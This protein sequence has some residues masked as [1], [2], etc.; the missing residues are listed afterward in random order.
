MSQDHRHWYRRLDGGLFQSG[1]GHFTPQERYNSFFD[2][3]NF[4]CSLGYPKKR[5][6]IKRETSTAPYRP[7]LKTV[8]E[9]NGRCHIH[10]GDRDLADTTNIF[11]MGVSFKVPTGFVLAPGNEV[12]ILMRPLDS[13]TMTDQVGLYEFRLYYLNDSGTPKVKLDIQTYKATVGAEVKSCT[14]TVTFAA[15][16]HRLDILYS[17]NGTP[18]GEAIVY[19]DAG[20]G[21]GN[22]GTTTFSGN[23]LWPAPSI[24]DG[25][26]KL[27][28]AGQV[29]VGSCPGDD[30]EKYGFT[31]EKPA[32]NWKFAE[33]RYDNAY[34]GTLSDDSGA[35][36]VDES[37]TQLDGADLDLVI[38]MDEG[39]GLVMDPET[40]LTFDD[41]VGCLTN[42]R[43]AWHDS[44][45]LLHGGYYE[46]H[47]GYVE[48]R[49]A[50]GTAP[51]E[52]IAGKDAAIIEP[53]WTMFFR[54]KIHE[55][56][57][58][59]GVTD[60]AFNV[61]ASHGFTDP[62]ATDESPTGWYFGFL[63]SGANWALGI[64]FKEGNAN[65]VS[66]F[67]AITSPY[68]GEFS[69]TFVRRNDGNLYY[70]DS[71]GGTGNI[72]FASTITMQLLGTEPLVFGAHFSSAVDEGRRKSN[73]K[74][75]NVVLREFRA[76]PYAI[77]AT[78]AADTTWETENADPSRDYLALIR[79][80][81]G[82]GDTCTDF[83]GNRL[84]CRI[85][86]SQ[87]NLPVESVTKLQDW[88]LAAGEYYVAFAEKPQSVRDEG[89][90][91]VEGTK[92]ALAAGQWAWDAVNDRIYVKDDPTNADMEALT[93]RGIVRYGDSL[94]MTWSYDFPDIATR[95]VDAVT[96]HHH[97]Q[98]GDKIVALGDGTAWEVTGNDLVPLDSDYG[99][100]EVPA[101]GTL[102]YMQYG[103][104]IYVTD[105]ANRPQVLEVNRFRPAGLEAPPDH[106]LP[107]VRGASGSNLDGY[108]TYAIAYENDEAGA[109]SDIAVTDPIELDN[110]GA[111]IGWH[112]DALTCR[113]FNQVDLNTTGS[114][115][116]IPA[117]HET[118]ILTWAP[119]D[120]WT[121]EGWIK[122]PTTATA[123]NINL[124]I[125]HK[126][127]AFTT[128]MFCAR[129]EADTMVMKFFAKN[130]ASTT[131]PQE[132][133]E[134]ATID[135][136]RE[137]G[138]DGEVKPTAQWFHVA[139]VWS[140]NSDAAD[141]NEYWIYLN[142]LLAADGKVQLSVV[143]AAG[144]VRI[145]DAPDPAHPTI[146]AANRCDYDEWRFWNEVRTAEQILRFATVPVAYAQNANLIMNFSPSDN[147]LDYL[148]V[149]ARE[150]AADGDRVLT[151]DTIRYD[152][153]NPIPRSRDFIT[154]IRIYRSQVAGLSSAPDGVER[155]AAK[156]IAEGGPWYYLGRVPVD[157]SHY[158]DT[159]LAEMASISDKRE[160]FQV[161]PP[162][163]ATSYIARY[164]AMAVYAKTAKYPERVWFSRPYY[165]EEL[166]SASTWFDVEDGSGEPITALHPHRGGLLVF[167][168]SSI[169]GIVGTEPS[170]LDV[171]LVAKG[172][173]TEA[174]RS[175]VEA[176]GAV[177]FWSRHGPAILTEGG[178]IPLGKG[179]VDVEIAK[180]TDYTAVIGVSDPTRHRVG[181]LVPNINDHPQIL[182]FDHNFKLWTRDTPYQE[183]ADIVGIDRVDSTE[184]DEIWLTDDKGYI[185]R[186][187]QGTHDGHM[188]HTVTLYGTIA[189]GTT[190]TGTF[191]NTG[192]GLTGLPVLI[193]ND[194]TGAYTWTYITTNTAN[195]A[196]IND[197][198]ASA[199]HWLLGPID[200]FLER[201]W[202]DWS[203]PNRTKHFQKFYL[204]P[205]S[206]D[207]TWTVDVAVVRELGELTPDPT[208]HF[209]EEVGYAHAGAAADP[210]GRFQFVI[211]E[212]GE[213][214][215]WIAKNPLPDS[216]NG[217]LE[218]GWEGKILPGTAPSTGHGTTSLYT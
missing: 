210:D 178:A 113:H 202:S 147:I 182:W 33:F 69:M 186:Y 91:L 21:G 212:M 3:S 74:Q 214:V 62:T 194:A 123:S 122:V 116:D 156:A 93:G 160:K 55:F 4:D 107:G 23:Y 52:R 164:G 185:Y 106:A 211:F 38:P 65:A 13:G 10:F 141:G 89:T 53:E 40:G 42:S 58:E 166:P 6:G 184:Q 9:K 172:V 215:K 90:N 87:T 200:F 119:G 86:G 142:G 162:P 80:Q 145:Y 199:S 198:V 88:T 148:D 47:P 96:T 175:V 57:G 149:V 183:Y 85:L 108:V 7:C 1:E 67:K 176:Q 24:A 197:S 205:S 216:P 103:G 37:Q 167:K 12:P 59:D 128:A 111:Y 213:R 63:K 61:I 126:S 54:F 102:D 124:W 193:R 46:N 180:C 127:D 181:W 79:F 201:A 207:Q 70:Y 77:S 92:G 25:T 170:R 118:T 95:P 64:L 218:A 134:I 140:G 209:S 169:W 84:V 76:L 2:G 190:L 117:H 196:T 155:E 99:V 179:W 50:D 94:P 130:P 83:S 208:Y 31:L 78:L 109:I 144:F 135:I 206:Y 204:R 188:Q 75:A 41:T 143:N 154:H 68:E 173:G 18:A 163:P 11:L 138:A 203:F 165:P 34:T 66:L 217:L 73:F 157:D 161:G 35:D 110:G 153:Q 133:K 22:T 39:G 16:W 129:I 48:V 20:A 177:Y 36:W 114:S 146:Q 15:G 195:A 14:G 32:Q 152:A 168:R 97:P 158:H 150:D 137:E 56:L 17:E 121:W 60:G 71:D 132:G 81:D 136:P 120:A 8:W 115:G 105:G 30:W 27:C 192:D 19:W 104:R 125:K 98:L 82:E 159:T 151:A 29:Y 43:P 189:S 191:Y 101:I 44:G 187:G 5:D 139:W 112:P 51:L 26:D 72:P 174:N 171:N 100:D 28:Y 131:V 45:L 49:N